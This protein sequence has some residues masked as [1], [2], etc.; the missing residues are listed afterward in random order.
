LGF[1]QTAFRFAHPRK[2][3][4]LAALES[5]S[6]EEDEQAAAERMKIEDVIRETDQVLAEKKRE[7]DE[8]KQLLEDQSSN[9]GSVAVGAAALGEA[10]D[11]D[12]IVQEERG[13]LAELQQQWREKLR[14]AEVDISVERAKL[15]REKAEI[16]EKL[17]RIEMR[18]GGPEGGDDDSAS[19][20]KPAR[21]RWLER[22]GLK[23]EKP[24]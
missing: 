2:Q 21:G 8:L 15:A 10:L 22:L 24:E 4:I 11:A 20:D 1:S 14:Q 16:E 18:G 17:R 12:A 3:R 19:S 6:D 13:K 5:D 9:L 7:C 23:D